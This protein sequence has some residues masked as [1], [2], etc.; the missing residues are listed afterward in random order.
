MQL[1]QIR[2]GWIISLPQVIDR[3]TDPNNRA[4]FVTWSNA[5]ILPRKYAVYQ[6]TVYMKTSLNE[7]T[8]RVTGFCMQIFHWSPRFP[9]T[10]GQWCGVLLVSLLLAITICCTQ[11]RSCDIKVMKSYPI[12]LIWLEKNKQIWFRLT[13]ICG[14]YVYFPCSPT[15]SLLVGK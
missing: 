13:N 6:I 1:K 14:L 5:P 7:N 12:G 2:A 11:C 10:K 4:D 8:F 15:G 3:N 9:L